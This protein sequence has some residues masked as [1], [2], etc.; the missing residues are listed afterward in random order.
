MLARA[1]FAKS[2]ASLA[3]ARSSAFPRSFQASFRAMGTRN[4]AEEARHKQ[5]MEKVVRG[6]FFPA[7]TDAWKPLFSF[8]WWWLKMRFF[9]TFSAARK[10]SRE[11]WE[12]GVY[13]Q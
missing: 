4:A 7:K 6:R 2:V 13:T 10:G 1:R 12:I 11:F 5:Q 3:S 9:G 8:F